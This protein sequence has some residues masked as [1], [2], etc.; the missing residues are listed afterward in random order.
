MPVTF[1]H[2]EELKK[3]SAENK[4]APVEQRSYLALELI[5]DALILTLEQELDED[6]ADEYEEEEAEE[7]EEADEAGE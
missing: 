1:E 4:N 2:I 7:E 5:A 6:L 3:R